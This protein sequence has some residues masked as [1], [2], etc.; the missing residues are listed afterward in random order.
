M[1]IERHKKTDF[2]NPEKEFPV[3]KIQNFVN[4]TG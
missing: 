1:K 4:D 2:L 3:D